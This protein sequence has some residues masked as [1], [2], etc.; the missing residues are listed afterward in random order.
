MK[1]TVE[2]LKRALQ[3]FNNDQIVNLCGGEDSEGGWASL[4]VGHMEHHNVNG[5]EY[6][7][8][9]GEYCIMDYSDNDDECE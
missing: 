4:E 8:F 7:T 1:M 5:F 9:V 6:D 3:E 2:Q